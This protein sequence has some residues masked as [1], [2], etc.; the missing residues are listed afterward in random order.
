MEEPPTLVFTLLRAKIVSLV[1]DII[2]QS[3][4][5]GR[6]EEPAVGDRGG[7][8]PNLDDVEVALGRDSDP[9]NAIIVALEEGFGHR[10]NHTID[11][12]SVSVVSVYLL[13]PCTTLIIFGSVPKRTESLLHQ[14]EHA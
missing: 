11:Q 12:D 6:I 2:A 1:R 10:V 13:G 3:H 5:Q 9:R 14:E 8:V 4:L 7:C